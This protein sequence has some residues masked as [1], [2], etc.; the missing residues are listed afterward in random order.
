MSRRHR[1][2]RWYP[3]LIVPAVA[4][5]AGELSAGA[6]LAGGMRMEVVLDDLAKV[7]RDTGQIH[8]EALRAVELPVAGSAWRLRLPMLVGTSGK[9]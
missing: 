6:A 2:L 1:Q 7:A 3:H 8:A 4:R 9:V 5:V